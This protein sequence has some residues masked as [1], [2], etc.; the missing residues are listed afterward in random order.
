MGIYEVFST[1]EECSMFVSCLT[2]DFGLHGDPVSD[3]GELAVWVSQDT[4]EEQQALVQKAA[5][6]VRQERRDYLEERRNYFQSLSTQDVEALWMTNLHS[7]RQLSHDEM[8]V[9]RVVV[10]MKKGLDI[11]VPM[12]VWVR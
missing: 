9:L 8:S 5:I 2:N 1:D 6:R 7:D 12:T 3:N 4:T 10:R 11:P